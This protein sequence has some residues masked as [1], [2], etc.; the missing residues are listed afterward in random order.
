M[1]SKTVGVYLEDKTRK[2]LVE[3]AESENRS[4][5]N[6]IATLIEKQADII[7]DIKAGNTQI[8][9]AIIRKQ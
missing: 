9:P 3:L 6:Y 1:A 2:K 7:D 4:I 8:D 5:S